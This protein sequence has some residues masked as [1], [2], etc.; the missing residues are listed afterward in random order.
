MT[1]TIAKTR[2]SRIRIGFPDNR[3]QWSES[4][5]VFSSHDLSIFGH[6][7]ME[8]WEAPY[9][10]DLARV[11]TCAGGEILEVGFGM[12]IS[13]SFIQSQEILAHTIIEANRD[14]YKKLLDFAQTAKHPV[15]PI[16]GFW[17]EACS[18]LP[19]QS[20]QGILFD[21]YPLREE[22]LHCN[23]FPFFSE[24]HRL[25]KSGGVLTYYSDEA[26]DFSPLHRQKLTQ[27][28]FSSFSNGI[29]KVNPPKHC[30]YWRHS[31]IMVPIVRKGG[32]K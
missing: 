7:V 27:A 9:M 6:P 25:L 5:A 16:F 31:T 22:D 15:I 28:G 32:N 20:F 23:H 13:A 4:E 30:R 10:Q 24:A 11:V 21:T 8:D 29:T 12:G 3:L 18:A 14:V 2:S 19:D 1:P 26:T 17:E